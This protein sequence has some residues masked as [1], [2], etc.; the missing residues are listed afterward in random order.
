ML[1]A[2]EPYDQGFGLLFDSQ[3]TPGME[4]IITPVLV[5]MCYP[6]IMRD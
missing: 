4:E 5:N 2:Q 1:V 3:V 6:Q